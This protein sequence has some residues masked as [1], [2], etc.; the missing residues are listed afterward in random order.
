MSRLSR[1]ADGVSNWFQR[2]LLPGFAFKALIIGGGYATGRELAEFFLPIGP[3]GGVIAMLVAAL[4]WSLVCALTFLFARMTGSLDYRTFFRHLL[5][6]GWVLFEIGFIALLITILAVFGAA[7]G[8]IGTA[9]FDWPAIA[10]TL[11]LVALIAG[12]AAFG[13]KTV[14]AL[15]KYVSFL[16]YGVYALFLLLALT[17]FGDR[18]GVAFTSSK[19]GEGWAF[20]GLTYSG[21]NVVGAVA[22][23]PIVRHFRCNRDAIAAGLLAGPLAMAPAILFFVCMVAWPEIGG[24]VLPS[25]FLLAKLDLPVFRFVFQLM[26]FAALLECGTGAV[27]ALNERIAGAVGPTRFDWRWRLA[28]SMVLL[29]G[30]VFL[31]DRFGLVALIA[32][33]YRYLSYGFLAIYVL[34]LL[35]HGVWQ[36]W[37]SRSGSNLPEVGPGVG[38]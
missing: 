26:I 31:A 35:T 38:R 29:I 7:S 9:L 18:I 14:E 8:A 34:P 37:R 25:D 16:L 15:F 3:W 36:M 30:S 11:L 19:I 28:V 21:Y 1:D 2:Y 10:G 12:F 24:V 13:S 22:I 17:S 6:P 33:G 32:S 4:I 27:H 23:L 20:A 5:G